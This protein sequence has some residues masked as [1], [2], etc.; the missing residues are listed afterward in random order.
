MRNPMSRISACLCCLLLSHVFYVQGQL[1]VDDQLSPGQLV[2]D[3][4][5]G[6]GVEVGDIRYTGSP[7]AICHFLDSTRMLGLN[8]GILLSTGDVAM[9]K[10]PNRSQFAGSYN[11]MTGDETL[12]SIARGRTYDA[13]ILEFDFVTV[14][15]DLTFRFVFASEE[16]DEYVG[17]KYNDVFGF[18]INKVGSNHV[19]NVARLEDDLTP[20]TINTINSQLN[21][22]YFKDNNYLNTFDMLIW[23]ERDKKY[24]KNRDYGKEPVEASYD[25]QYDGFTTVLTAR[26]RVIPNQKYH[27]KMAIADVSDGIYDSG[28]FLEAH[29]FISSGQIIASLDRHFPQELPELR[30]EEISA[31]ER[32]NLLA[33]QEF[34]QGINEEMDKITEEE[35]ITQAGKERKNIN[36]PDSLTRVHFEFD[37]YNITSEANTILE[38]VAEILKKERQIHVKIK[39]HTDAKGA[40]NYNLL[41]SEN[42]SLSV[43]SLLQQY[44]VPP[45]RL[46]ISYFGEELPLATNDNSPGRALNRRVELVFDDSHMG[47]IDSH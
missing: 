44:G 43:A 5:L 14:S 11:Y 28:V 8:E 36:I 33:E 34:L 23:D 45:E 2:R 47:F 6:D 40:D 38:R 32:Q 19:T 25:L 3:V 30:H 20:I 15:E 35:L 16:Y 26:M 13:A 22:K 4:L 42:R 17:S 7:N 41:L 24:V 9:A 27:I 21:K 46:S 31:E 10:G 12:E 37:K 18:F 1:I 39:G 29:S